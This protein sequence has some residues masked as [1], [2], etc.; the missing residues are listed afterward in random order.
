M[1]F[2]EF[3]LNENR[4][5]LGQKVGDILAATQDISQNSEHIGTRQLVKNS[6][7]IVNQIRRI[8][9]TNWPK[10]EEGNLEQL[11]KIAVAI[12]SAIEEKD[13]LAG[14]LAGAQAELEQLSEKL[15]V[16]INTLG[17]PEGVE[18]PGDTD[19]DIGVA[20]PQ[21]EEEEE[22]PQQPQQPQGQPQMPPGG[23]QGQQPGMPPQGQQG[24]MMQPGMNMAPPFGTGTPGGV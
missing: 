23:M 15:G 3:L 24:P 9:H 20:E 6:Q 12:S 13:D 21:G 2:N 4:A 14:I 17:S 1:R 16:P 22:A 5:Y 18:E 10:E 19:A 11:Q 8:L 7:G